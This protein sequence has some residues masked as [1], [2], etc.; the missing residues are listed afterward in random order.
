MPPEPT[1][2]LT[3]VLQGLALNR[4]PGWNFPGN[5]LALSFDAVSDDS[6]Q[7]SL[8]PGP[9]CTDRDGQVNLAALCLLADVAM[10]VTMRRR[11]GLAGRLATVSMTLQFTGAPRI[12]RLEAQGRLRDLSVG[13]AA[14]QGLVDTEILAG[15]TRVC[16]GSGS[17]IALGDRPG[18]APLPMRRRGHD[19]PLPALAPAELSEDESQVYSR[20]QAARNATDASFIEAFWGLRP[21]RGATGAVCD[22]TNGLHVGNRVGHTQGG[23]TCALAALTANAAFDDSWQ[24]V[25]ASASYLSPGLGASLRAEATV[26]HQG[27]LTAVAHTTIRNPE[28][29]LVLDV[30]TQH[31]RRA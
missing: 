3:Q 14:P 7:L 31:A 12:G 28:G 19:A 15:P 24:L 23:I 17:F 18:L 10:A 25:G 9:H 27:R 30:V 20:A 6:S 11:L 29:R 21:Q 22:F 16:L 4:Q 26:L 2:E 13:T 8:D 1:P 5:F